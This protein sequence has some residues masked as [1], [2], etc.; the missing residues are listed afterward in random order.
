[1]LL[2]L[3]ETLTVPRLQAST[4]GQAARDSLQLDA[5][6]ATFTGRAT[7][8]IGRVQRKKCV[9]QN[10]LWPPC[11]ESINIGK[12]DVASNFGKMILSF[13]ALCLEYRELGRKRNAYYM[14]R[15]FWASNTFHMERVYYEKSR[16]SLTWCL[17]I[18]FR[19]LISADTA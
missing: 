13:A 4:G 5:E 10:L 2:I 3:L 18:A 7:A 15:C 8:S 1:M 9:D 14:R 19:F 11:V 6:L 16:Y 12:P 17:C